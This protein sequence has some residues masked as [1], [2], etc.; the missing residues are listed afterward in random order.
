MPEGIIASLNCR[1]IALLTIRVLPARVRKLRLHTGG[2]TRRWLVK[3]EFRPD[4]NDR[5]SRPRHPLDN[6][7]EKT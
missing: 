5:T 1:E 2:L 7:I 4:V 6:H 3:V